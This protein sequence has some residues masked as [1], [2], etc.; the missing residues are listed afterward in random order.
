MF[1]DPGVD[2]PLWCE[3]RGSREPSASWVP[4]AVLCTSARTHAVGFPPLGSA[5]NN[6]KKDFFC[7]REILLG[8]DT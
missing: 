1:V 2:P 7:L 6:W 5:G 8:Q 3:P 4:G